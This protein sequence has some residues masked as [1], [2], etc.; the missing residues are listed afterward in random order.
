MRIKGVAT[1]ARGE[2]VGIYQHWL[3]ESDFEGVATLRTLLYAGP[4][5]ERWLVEFQDEPGKLY[6]RSILPRG[7]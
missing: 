1:H 5:E 2:R 6:A 3:E 7:M 4:D